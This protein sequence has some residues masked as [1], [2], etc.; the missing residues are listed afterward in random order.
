MKTV[1][2][3]T[4][5]ITDWD[6]FHSE[7]A[8]LM[9]FPSFYGRN[10]NAW[11]D[12]M[13]YLTDANTGM[14]KITLENGESLVISVSDSESFKKRLPEIFEGLIECAAFVNQRY[15]EAGQTSVVALAFQ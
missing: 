7:F 1:R 6:S 8:E 4:K 13:S 12:C 15:E 5:S 3:E 11:I 9:G 10:M 14:S 2:L